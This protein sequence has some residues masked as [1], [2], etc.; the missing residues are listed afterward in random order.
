[1]K[2]IIAILLI[3]VLL[4]GCYTKK[5]K[6][7]PELYYAAAYSFVGPNV[8]LSPSIREYAIEADIE[9]DQYGREL[10]VIWIQS[11]DFYGNLDDNFCPSEAM[12]IVQKY[13]DNKVYYYEDF[14]FLFETKE[15]YPEDQVGAFKAKN[16]WDSPIN[17]EKCSSR[18]YW[19]YNM[20]PNSYWNT[21][22]NDSVAETFPNLTCS[23]Y[24]T[25][26]KDG[27]VLFG[28]LTHQDNL[29]KSY[30]VIYDPTISG[31]DQEKGIMELTSLDFGADLHELKIRN[32][33]NFTECPG[34]T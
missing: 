24:V 28:V 2:R 20:F 6:D 15:G 19:D 5:A 33:W 18:F 22:V 10:F 34:D 26:D 32:G 27:K 21:N 31:I 25:A 14:C 4:L 7:R 17:E 30:Y 29:Y 16:D 8:V 13:D 11:V 9:T 3:V 12:V 23:Y 1:M